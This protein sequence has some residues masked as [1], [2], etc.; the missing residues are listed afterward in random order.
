MDRPHCFVLMPFG[1][2]PEAAGSMVDFD[3]AFRDLMAPAIAEAALEPL[4]ADEELTG[5]II[6]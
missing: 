2:G 4:R 6:H 3:A 1:R 5:G